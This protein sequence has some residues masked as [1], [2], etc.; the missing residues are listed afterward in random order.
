MVN[1]PLLHRW[2]QIL[3]RV[4]LSRCFISVTGIQFDEFLGIQ[5]PGSFTIAIDSSIYS[6]D[7]TVINTVQVWTTLKYIY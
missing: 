4:H 2:R 6:R 3:V 5:R 1:V 7:S